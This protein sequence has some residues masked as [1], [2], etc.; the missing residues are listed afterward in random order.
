[1]LARGVVLTTVLWLPWTRITLMIRIQGNSSFAFFLA[2][3]GYQPGLIRCLIYC[4]HL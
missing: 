3:G 1:M 2:L 4:D